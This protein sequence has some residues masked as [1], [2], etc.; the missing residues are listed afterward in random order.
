[1]SNAFDEE[2]HKDGMLPNNI[3]LDSNQRKSLKIS[4]KFTLLFL[5]IQYFDSLTN[6]LW[7]Q[8]GVKANK[9]R[10]ERLNVCLCH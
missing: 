1:M 2:K 10:P 6:T 4:E 8:A 7:T 5:Q 9:F 3:N